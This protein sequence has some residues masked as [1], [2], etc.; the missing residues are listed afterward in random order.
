MVLR[1]LGRIHKSGVLNN[2]IV[3]LQEHEYNVGDN[4]DKVAFQEPMSSSQYFL[5]MN[6]M[7]YEIIKFHVPKMKYGS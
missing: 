6:P 2:Y 1:R 7:K 4:P 3:Y 5:W